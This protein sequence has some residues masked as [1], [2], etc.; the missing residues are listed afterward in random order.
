MRN[1][2]RNDGEEESRRGRNGY[3]GAGKKAGPS[4][5]A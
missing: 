2:G 1:E 5:V 3:A 4:A